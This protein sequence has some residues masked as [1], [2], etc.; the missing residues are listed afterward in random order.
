MTR[1]KDFKRLVHA[2]MLKTG[3]AYTAARA[4]SSANLYRPS[5]ARCHNNH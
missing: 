1:Q 2:R 4:R 5:R 3:E